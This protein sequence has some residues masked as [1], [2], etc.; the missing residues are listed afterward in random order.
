[1]AGGFSS[2]W[3]ANE[4]FFG[5]LKEKGQTAGAMNFLPAKKD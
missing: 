3:I 5:A 2:S 4:M 1:M